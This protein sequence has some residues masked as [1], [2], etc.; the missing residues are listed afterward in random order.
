VSIAGRDVRKPLVLFPAV[1]GGVTMTIIVNTAADA[2][3]ILDRFIA[4]PSSRV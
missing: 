2:M 1:A 4:T 3:S